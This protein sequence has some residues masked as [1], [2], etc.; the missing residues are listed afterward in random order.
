MRQL[1]IHKKYSIEIFFITTITRL[2]YVELFN[3]VDIY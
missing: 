1:S 2:D 3:K